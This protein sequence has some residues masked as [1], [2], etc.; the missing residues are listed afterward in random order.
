MPNQLRGARQGWRE[1]KEPWNGRYDC[2]VC[3][4]FKQV[5]DLSNGCFMIF[6][7]L[8]QAKALAEKNKRDFLAQKEQAERN[9]IFYSTFF[10]QEISKLSKNACSLLT[11]L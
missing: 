5:D 9:V 8:F 7:C 1:T 6:L 2:Y 10:F 11:I 4:Y 3:S